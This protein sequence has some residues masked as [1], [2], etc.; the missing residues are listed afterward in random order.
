M[1]TGR[2]SQ[3]TTAADLS[4]LSLLLAACRAVS[5]RRFQVCALAVLLGV[6]IIIVRVH[7]SYALCLKFEGRSSLMDCWTHQFKSIKK[8]RGVSKVLEEDVI[9]LVEQR[10]G[11]MKRPAN[12][13][14]DDT[15]DSRQGR[16]IAREGMEGKWPSFV[17]IP[18]QGV[19]MYS[20]IVCC[21]VIT[22]SV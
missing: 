18:V 9:A 19:F 14:I 11:T 6:L 12:D 1:F 5:L 13:V 3:R 20:L 21:M 2:K 10:Y 8:E 7:V 16:R 4:C 22:T 15:N 17:F